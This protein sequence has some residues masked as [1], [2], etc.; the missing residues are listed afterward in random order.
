MSPLRKSPDGTSPVTGRNKRLPDGLGIILEFVDGVEKGRRVPILFERTVLGRKD[1][2]ILVRDIQVSAAHLALEYREG[3]FRIAD[4]GSSNGTFVGGTR[5]RE[6]KLRIGEEVR[7][8]DG[9]FRLIV[10]PDL[11]M[12]LAADRPTRPAPRSG[13]L[14]ELIA[15]EFSVP[16]DRTVSPRIEEPPRSETKPNIRLR[17][18][19]GPDRGKRFAFSGGSVII[20]RLNADVSLSDPDV[21]RKHAVLERGEGGQVIL[22]DLASVNGTLVNERAV[23]NCVLSPADRIGVGRTTLVFEGVDEK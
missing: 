14:S 2:D 7:I 8:G 16:D 15:L 9:A 22:R 17:V 1:A 19:A 11:A 18:V 3:M 20:G 13:G 4:L 10:D 5:V 12:R 6:R 21:S 23:G